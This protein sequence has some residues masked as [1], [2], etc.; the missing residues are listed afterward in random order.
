MRRWFPREWVRRPDRRAFNEHHTLLALAATDIPVPRALWLDEKGHIFGV[1]AT[2]Q[3]RLAGRA[4]WP[5]AIPATRAAQ[6]GD[7]LARIHA[8]P[9]PEDVPPTQMW[10]EPF[11]AHA[12]PP[13]IFRDKHPAMPTIW[14]ALKHAGTAPLEHDRVLLHGDYHAGNT[15]WSRG[16]LS[17]IVDWETVEAGPRGRDLG[18]SSMDCTITGGREMASAMIGGYGAEP[19]DMWFWELLAAVQA[20]AFYRDWQEVWRHYGLADLSLRVVR[21]RLDAFIDRTL[22][23]I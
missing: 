17:G 6:M 9:P 1:P 8:C 14:G 4:S 3:T 13:P 20:M 18:Y 2:I 7:A 5:E 12:K 11:L 23:S 10:V 21:R 16:R 19:A 15:L 22:R